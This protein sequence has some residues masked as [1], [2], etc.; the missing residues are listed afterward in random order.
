MIYE[1]AHDLTDKKHNYKKALI[2]FLKE[3]GG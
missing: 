2:R 3:V 1:D